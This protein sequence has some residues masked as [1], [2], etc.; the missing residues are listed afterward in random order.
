MYS[1]PCAKAVK[2]SNVVAV[3]QVFQVTLVCYGCFGSSVA[4]S[5]ISIL[6]FPT[7]GASLT[8][9][10]EPTI[11]FPDIC[12]NHGGSGGMDDI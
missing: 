9:F 8:P 4:A 7:M 2:H 12:M 6:V 10:M 3:A 11:M 5:I 1:C